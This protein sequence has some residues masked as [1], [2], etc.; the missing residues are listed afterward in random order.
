[1]LE[2][3]FPDFKGVSFALLFRDTEVHSNEGKIIV[4]VRDGN[5][6]NGFSVK[7]ANPVGIFIQELKSQMFVNSKIPLNVVSPVASSLIVF[8]VVVSDD[9]GHSSWKLL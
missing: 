9:K 1:M 7:Y 8:W 5:A 6:G 2:C 4:K 3:L